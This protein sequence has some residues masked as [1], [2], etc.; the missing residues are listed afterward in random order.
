MCLQ[1]VPVTSVVSFSARVQGDATW[2]A[3]AGQALPREHRTASPSS[4]TS[5]PFQ[6]PAQM[7]PPD[8][9]TG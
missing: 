6:V 1:S 8:S 4:G 9:V 5:P 3:C 2:N 7:Q